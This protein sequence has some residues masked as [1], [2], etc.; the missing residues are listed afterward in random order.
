MRGKDTRGPTALLKSAMKIDQASFQATL[1]NVKFH[2]SAMKTTEDLRKLSMLIRTYFI[3]GGK[4]IQFN[5]VNR[6]TLTDAQEH[7][8]SHGDLVVRIAGYS[9]YFVQLDKVMQD[10]IVARTEHDWVG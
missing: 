7:P 8:E 2:P 4:H 6:E 9:A 1:L 10:E 3:E 5:V